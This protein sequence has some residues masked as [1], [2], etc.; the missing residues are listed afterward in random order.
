LD[1]KS[2]HISAA[3]KWHILA[4][5]ASLVLSSSAHA[6][7]GGADR[8][9]YKTTEKFEMM[10][11]SGEMRTLIDEGRAN[12]EAFRRVQ[13]LERQQLETT[14]STGSRGA[15]PLLRN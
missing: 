7:R 6:A 10:H 11:R 3:V 5:A 15:P 1:S 14:G 2:P 8:N 12:V 4:I 13:E 9:W